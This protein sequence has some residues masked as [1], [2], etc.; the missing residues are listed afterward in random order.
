M[1]HKFVRTPANNKIKTWSTLGVFRPWGFYK[2][3]EPREIETVFLV[4]EFPGKNVK[5]A[6]GASNQKEVIEYRQ[7]LRLLWGIRGGSNPSNSVC[8]LPFLTYQTIQFL[9]HLDSIFGELLPVTTHWR[10]FF[11]GSFRYRRIYKLKNMLLAPKKR[12]LGFRPPP[13]CLSLKV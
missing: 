2:W 11:L 3:A 4:N 5:C 13:L 1:Q 7:N 8:S 10:I 6:W 9:T 12:G